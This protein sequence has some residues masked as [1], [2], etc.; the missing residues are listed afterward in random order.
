MAT[1]RV[2][3]LTKIGQS[4]WYDYIQ[5]SMIT[6]GELARLVEDEGLRGI[7]SNPTIFEKAIGGSSDYDNPLKTLFAQDKSVMEIYESL[8]IEDIQ[9]ACDV[10]LFLF[11]YTGGKDG[12]VSLEVSPKLAYDTEGTITEANR[13]YSLI[14]RPNLMIKIPATLEGLPAITSV[15]ASGI[16]VNV[17]LIFSVDRYVQVVEAY[18]K[19][20]EQLRDAGRPL[21]KVA[22]VASF[23]ISRMDTLVDK[24]LDEKIKLQQ[25]PMQKENLK[26]LQGK[27]AIAN[28]K[29]AYQKYKELFDSYRFKALAAKGAKP[30][31]PLWAS[32]GTKNPLYSDLLYVNELIAPNTVNTVPP[33][34][35]TAFLDHGIAALTLDSEIGDAKGV[36]EK[37]E[38]AGITLANVTKQLEDEGVKAFSNSFNMLMRTIIAKKL[39]LENKIKDCVKLSLGSFS[40]VVSETLERLKKEQVAVKIWN[41]EVSLWKK[42]P[43]HQK[44]IKNSLGWLAVVDFAKEHIQELKS[45]AQEVCREG[46][47]HI[48]WFGMGGSSLA[49]LVLSQLF[50]KK[51]G[52]PEFIVLDSTHPAAVLAVEQHIN[53]SST[54]FVAASKSGT[55]TE[56]TAFYS[57]FR[58]KVKVVAGSSAGRHFVAITDPGTQLEHIASKEQFRKV[59]LNPP[60]IGGRYSALSYFGIAGAALLGIDLDGFLKL[61]DETVSSTLPCVPVEQN[62]GLL[63]GGII[64]E[65]ANKGLDKLTIITSK[66]LHTFGLWLEQLIAESTGKE[67]RGIIPVVEKAPSSFGIYSYDRL[68]VYIEF[69]AEPEPEIK[70]KLK[71]LEEAGHPVVRIS[72]PDKLY[73]GGE[74]FRWEFAVSVAGYILGVN[75][76]DQPDVEASKVKTRSFLAQ[77]K[78]NKSLPQ[79]Q[80]FV[81][82]DGLTLFGDV[83]SSEKVV[84]ALRSFLWTV[85]PGDYVAIMAYLEP[86]SSNEKELEYIRHSISAACKTAVTVGFGPR[87]LHSTGQLHKGG[88]DTGLFIQ[89]TSSCLKDLPV[90]Q[91]EYGFGTLIEAQ[92][93]G[94]FETLRERKRRL[95]RIHLEED[96]AKGMKRLKSLIDEAASVKS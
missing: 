4:L 19:G 86:S 5:R 7:T 79:L 67:G 6:S 91:D 36:L 13:L 43:E 54:L 35:W 81:Q 33:Q 2:E 87:F 64:G 28:A 63:L 80:Q 61:A 66:Q 42:D 71:E 82:G 44:I 26:K 41:K 20:L 78:T 95:I 55:T 16:N 60:D 74:F 31:R 51:E 30:Q 85:K 76:F 8:I 3:E 34:T 77:Y 46:F 10:F 62:S 93:L 18:L 21:D 58:E 70:A 57:Y 49:P 65:L 37:V 83:A 56:V 25:Y 94:D 39:I 69:A 90:S 47:S 38:G 23:F 59:F 68:L 1:K 84:P 96:P 11:E 27:S 22:S 32:T 88:K 52:Y 29:M 12:F 9:K 75:P 89:I 15:I 53:I 92:A 48:V 72:I 24:L 17:T 45:F 14:G 73:L 40:G 50:G